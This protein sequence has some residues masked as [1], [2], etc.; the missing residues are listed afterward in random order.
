[1][2]RLVNSA[3]TTRVHPQS[4]TNLTPTFHTGFLWV[5]STPILWTECPLG[6]G[7]ALEALLKCSVRFFIPKESMPLTLCN[8]YQCNNSWYLGV[9]L[10]IHTKFISTHPSTIS[11]PPIYLIHPQR[12][13]A[14]TWLLSQVLGLDK[15]NLAI[16]RVRSAA[17]TASG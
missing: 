11:L 16:P 1:M 6:A 2:F 14:N 13:A 12:T 3:G 4:E 8:I 10:H 7:I 17:S 15:I 9:T 5:D